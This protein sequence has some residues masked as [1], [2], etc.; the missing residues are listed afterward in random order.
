MDAILETLQHCPRS[1][2]CLTKFAVE[3]TTDGALWMDASG[4]LLFVNQ[5][6]SFLLGYDDRELLVMNVS[7]LSPELQARVEVGAAETE[8]FQA[9]CYARDRR[10]LAVEVSL[11]RFEAE[12]SRYY[13][14]FLHDL[15]ERKQMEQQLRQAHKM[16]AVGRL[17]DGVAHDFNNVLTAVMIYGGLLLNQLTSESPLR[18]PANQ[19]L[20]A[21][22]HGRNLIAQLLSFGRGHAAEARACSFSLAGML[23]GMSEMLRH[24]LG[25]D[26]IL[27]V[28]CA[29]DLS[30]VMADRTELEQVIMNLALNARDAMAEGGT[31]NI[32]AENLV[33]QRPRMSAS[34][35][36]RITVSDTG[37]GM[38]ADTLAHVF[39]PFF[40]TKPR[41]RGSGLG[42]ATVYRCITDAGGQID[43]QSRPAEG[44]TVTVLLPAA[45]RVA[46]ARPRLASDPD[47]RGTETVLVVEDD[48][49]VRR[50][51]CEI[52]RQRGYEVLQARDGR[53][54]RQRALEFPGHIHLLVTDL[55][56][57][58]GSG[59]ELAEK[60]KEI[61]P[62]M[63]VLYMSGYTED[64]RVR[65][66]TAAGA[67]FCSKPFTAATLARKL[68]EVLAQPESTASGG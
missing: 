2:T 23:A 46:A 39:E 56:L 22:E 49:L 8:R 52:L 21:A 33:R 63:R 59:R 53:E 64:A 3:H 17:V 36:L 19:I 42:L 1:Q 29:S 37:C 15:S 13:S 68:R 25:E 4:N 47:W 51:V 48:E 35:W 30:P 38:D 18:K 67:P 32:T 43:I 65:Q 54:A 60:V 41:G 11:T 10:P 40:T 16:E 34:G 44:T 31:L 14:A 9:T 45:G 62:E 57:P 12:G 7:Q 66:L 26:V 50:S 20:A 61:R 58:G 6:A 27:S 24:L 5:A 28:N 55:V